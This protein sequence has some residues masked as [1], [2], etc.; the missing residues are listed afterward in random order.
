MSQTERGNTYFLQMID[1]NT[2]FAATAA[3]SNQQ[4]ETIKEVLWPKW[5]SYFGI[6]KSL[7]SDQGQ[8]VD[9]KVIRDLCKRLNIVKMYS[10]PYHPE[11]NGSTEKTIGLIKTIIRTM[12]QARSVPVED[13]DLLL[14]EATLAYNNTV[15]KSRGFSPFRRLFG[16]RAILP[17]DRVC[18]TG[19]K[20]V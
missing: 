10:T 9:G 8:N 13:W 11:G 5:F 4:A 17:I 20:D 12:C 16:R 14:D 2:K 6:P 1:A 3:I 7:L 15:N 18:Q 19:P